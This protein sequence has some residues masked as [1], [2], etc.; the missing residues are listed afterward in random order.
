ML[1]QNPVFSMNTGFFSAQ[2]YFEFP[3]LDPQLDPIKL[4]DI[5]FQMISDEKQSQPLP[6]PIA[7]SD[8]ES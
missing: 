3:N 7:Y 4:T 5:G 2:N 6:S 8:N 1:H